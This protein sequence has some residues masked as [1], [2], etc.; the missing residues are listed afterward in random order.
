[1][2]IMLAYLILLAEIKGFTHYLLLCSLLTLLVS[3]RVFKYL[4]K[5]QGIQSFPVVDN[6]ELRCGKKGKHHVHT[7]ALPLTVYSYQRW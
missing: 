1:M 5:R 3:P 7:P 4:A 2:V 6:I